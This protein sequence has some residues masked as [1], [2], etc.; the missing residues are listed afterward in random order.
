MT[1]TLD[2]PP[3]RLIPRKPLTSPTPGSL[4]IPTMGAATQEPDAPDTVTPSVSYRVAETQEPVTH[5]VAETQEPAMAETQETATAETQEP[6]ADIQ[7]ELQESDAQTSFVFNKEA[8]TQSA[9]HPVAAT[10]EPVTDVEIEF[11]ES[12]AQDAATP[13]S[14]SKSD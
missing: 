11:R 13:P 2:P 3:I 12:Q 8:E 9:T 14:S 4:P 10:Q 7:I 1:T 6:A 5:S